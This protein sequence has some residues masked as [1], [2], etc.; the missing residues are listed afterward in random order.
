MGPLNLH[1]WIDAHRD[2]LRPPVGNARLFEDGSFII[3]VVGGPNARADFHVDP[4]DELFFQVEGDME[5]VVMEAGQRR[6]IR[7]RAGELFLL[8]GGVPHSPQRPAGT[9]GLVVERKRGPGEQDAL[10]WFCST[11]QARVH[12]A[13]FELEDIVTQIREAIE[14]LEA[15]EAARTCGECGAVLDLSAP[16]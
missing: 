5:L 7:I 9:V 10:Q 13:R 15:D 16:L 1:A 8:P 12:E 6:R 2:Q 3:M 11:C 14:V 4:H